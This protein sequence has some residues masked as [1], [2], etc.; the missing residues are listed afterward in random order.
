MV[1]AI[2][3]GGGGARGAFQAGVWSAL[4]PLIQPQFVIGS[5]IGAVNAWATTRLAPSAL[6][7]WWL[8]AAPN[9]LLPYAKGTFAPVLAR[10]A[11]LPRRANWPALAVCTPLGRPG[12][13]VVTLSAAHAANWL[14][15]SCALPGWFAPVKVAGHWYID[16]GVRNDLP[17]T[18]AQA[19]G[20]T[21]IIAIGAG[22]L[23]PTP[24]AET[25]PNILP[26]AGLGKMFD[27]SK[28]AR[29]KALMAGR[30]A[31]AEWIAS[32]EFRRLVEISSKRVQNGK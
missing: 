12:S 25:V 32:T 9:R 26:P 27:W 15:A 18:I 17:V 8:T 16:G 31:G 6:C 2:V 24:Q 10:L 29:Q 14:A 4:A 23:G 19:L 22:G 30:Q 13:H 5:S 20:A 3:F 28:K 21:A 7:Q 11:Q 1:L